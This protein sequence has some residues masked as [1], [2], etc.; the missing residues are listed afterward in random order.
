MVDALDTLLNDGS[1]IEIGGD[2]VRCGANQ[3]DST[4]MCLVIGTG[5]F[6]RWEE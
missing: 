6:E 2:I 3:F 1:L 4:V 5:T